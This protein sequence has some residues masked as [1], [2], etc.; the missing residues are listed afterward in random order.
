MLLQT[1]WK[2]ERL[3]AAKSPLENDKNLIQR[4]PLIKKKKQ[5]KTNKQTNKHNAK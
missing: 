5:Q 1:R 3:K 2:I 4:S